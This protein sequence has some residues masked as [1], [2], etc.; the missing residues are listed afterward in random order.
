MN[1]EILSEKTL[2]HNNFDA[3]NRRV[4]NT[5][6]EDSYKLVRDTER[7][8]SGGKNNLTDRGTYYGVC[9]EEEDRS[10]DTGTFGESTV[11]KAQQNQLFQARQTLQSAIQKSEDQLIQIVM[12]SPS[13]KIEAN[14]NE[15]DVHHQIFGAT[16]TC[17]E[18]E[19]LGKIEAGKPAQVCSR[20]ARY[21]SHSEKKISQNQIAQP[22]NIT[23][24]TPVPIDMEMFIIQQIKKQ[25]EP[26][27][28]KLQ[29]NIV[30]TKTV[31]MK[32]ETSLNSEL[33][34]TQIQP[35]VINLPRFSH[36][37]PPQPN[38]DL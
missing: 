26:F 9:R 16:K 38:M 3:R 8:S 37:G 34:I 18:Q 15:E 10:H 27:S 21:V 7:F 32:T 29:E 24:N 4:S 12:G 35:L 11:I 23:G 33:D 19:V 2:N 28:T 14:R 20:A 5:E 30:Q 17:T 1:R 31:T 36:Q 22:L 13:K 6:H 25:F